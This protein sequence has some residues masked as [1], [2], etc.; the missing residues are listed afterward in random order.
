[1]YGWEGNNAMVGFR[2]QSRMVRF[3]IPLPAKD[4]DEFRYTAAKKRERAEDDRYKAWEQAMRQRWR[5]LALVVKAKLEAVDSGITT[6]DKEF[7]A[8]I[9]LPDGR[10]VSDFMVPQI[11]EAYDTG[12]MP[13]MLPLLGPGAP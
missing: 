10:T 12:K 7:M 4:A 13:P 6:F 1:M 5:A 9:L 2:M 11:K 8:H 3:L